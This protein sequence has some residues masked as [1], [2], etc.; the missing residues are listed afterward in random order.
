MLSGLEEG[1][2]IPANLDLIRTNRLKELYSNLSLLTII[3]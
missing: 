1:D 3:S 2:G